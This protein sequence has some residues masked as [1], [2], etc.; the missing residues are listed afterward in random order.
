MQGSKTQDK[1]QFD[2][3]E[4]VARTDDSNWWEWKDVSCIFFWIWTM[5]WYDEAS[6]GSQF[7]NNGLPQPCL[8]FQSPPIKEEW[9][10]KLDMFK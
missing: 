1:D 3:Y 9:I 10:R 6:N 4:C 5:L 7:F 8:N 2:I